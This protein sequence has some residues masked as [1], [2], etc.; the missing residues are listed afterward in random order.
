MNNIT[1]ISDAKIAWRKEASDY[2]CELADRVCSGDITEF[3]VVMHDRKEASFERYG[4]FEDRW[5][6]LGAIEYAKGAVELG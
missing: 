2:L 1:P 3:V 4:H 6:L 5:R